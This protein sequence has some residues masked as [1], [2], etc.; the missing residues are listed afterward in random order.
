MNLIDTAPHEFNANF[1]FTDDGLSPFF[2]ADS[3]VKDHDGATESTFRHDGE[4]WRAKLYYQD[5]NILHPGDNTPQ[6]T[7]FH[8]E[9]VREFRI[10]VEATDDPVGQRSFNAHLRPR[11]AGMEVEN[12]YGAEQELSVPFDEGVNVR[13]T[14]SNIEF[15]QYINLLQQAARSIGITWTYFADPHPTSNVQQAERYVRVHRDESGPVHARDGPLAQLGHVLEGDRDGHRK[16]E[17]RDMDERG[18]QLPGYRHQTAVD[19]HRVQEI[20]PDHNLPK[21]WKHYYAREALDRD[22]SDTMAHPKVGAI[23]Q[24]S[25][26]RDPDRKLGVSPDDLSTLTREL[27][28]GLL[29]I[30]SDA[31][32]DVSST[33]QFVDDAYF[34]NTTSDRERQVVELPIRQIRENQES[35]VIQHIADGLSPVQWES[36]ETLVTDGGEIAPKDIA[37]DGGFHLDS[38]YRALDGIEAMIDRE[39]GSVQLRSTHVGQL[40]HDAVQK[41]RQGAREAVEAAGKAIDAADRGMDDRTSALVAWASKHADTFR[42][43]DGGLDIDFGTIS[44]DG[45]DDAKQEIRRR[46]REGYEI[47]TDARKDE[48]TWRIGQY[49]ARVEYDKHADANYLSETVTKSIT[50]QL[51]DPI[52]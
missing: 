28:E 2:A 15:G 17:Q 9:E 41:A 20:L 19:E 5:S 13:I 18:D 43:S 12:E 21:R 11:W 7:P 44:A 42:E 33:T 22:E 30:L 48:T 45:L 26:W 38:V 14:G 47:W 32:L 3:V 36:L 16:V 8:I 34:E 10:A 50:G 27:E 49:R 29:S 51:H 6:G 40:V 46:L 4:R 31:G 23:Y 25:L 24:G 39:Y 37:E 52:D 1:N 35:V